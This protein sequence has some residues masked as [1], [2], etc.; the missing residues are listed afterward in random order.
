MRRNL[1]SAFAAAGL[2]AAVVTGSGLASS[3]STEADP[4]VIGAAVAKTGWL[5]SAD[6][7][8]LNAFMMYID[9]VNAA[10]GING[11]KL[12]IISADNQTD[13]AKAKTAAEQLI[14]RGAQIILGS[15]NF[16]IGGPAGIYAQS[17][18]ILNVSLGAGSP[19]WGVQGIGPQ[20]YSLGE[21][22]YGEGWAMADFA[23]KQGWT[24]AFVLDDT[25]LDYSAQICDG[26]QERWKQLGG[27]TAGT[28]EFKNSDASVATQVG[29]IGP[30]GAGFVALCTYAPGGVTAIRQIRS[31]GIQLPVVSDF[32]M[33]GTSWL[34]A[35]PN[36]SDFYTTSWGSV[37][38]DDPSAAVNKFVKDYAAR[39]GKSGLQ[40]TAI[41]CGY[42]AA[43]DIVAAIKRAGGSTS[44]PALTAQF[45]KFR[46]FPS[47]I[48]TTYSPTVHIQSGGSKL[49]IL[50][51]T[52][53]K[54]A[55]FTTMTVP[56]NVNL[57]S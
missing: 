24:K 51:L 2:M 35:V 34:T 17:K 28:A 44:G 26:F 10:G 32:G 57:H 39:Y 11:R 23:H 46:N 33:T 30:S 38:G 49:R 37:Y 5:N 31:A 15:A 50:K 13:P 45:N 8:A 53:G 16:A 9:K 42:V 18:N 19:A 6:G 54:P 40:N 43:Q 22:T 52:N 21:A 55:Y 25:S 12:K 3:A 27:A 20:A 7:T 1:I 48:P 4:I 41:F 14:S 29:Q 36:L 56:K 47:L